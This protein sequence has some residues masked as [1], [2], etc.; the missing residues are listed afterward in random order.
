MLLLACGSSHA[1]LGEKRST[2][3]TGTT[4]STT[5]APQLRAQASTLQTAGVTQQA[6]PLPN[7]T[8][9]VEYMDRNGTVFAVTWEGPVL[10]DLP[11]TLGR[12][13]A[14]FKSEVQQL[15]TASRR[16]G[17][18]NLRGSDLV[19]HSEG[20]MRRFSGYAYVVSLVPPGLN[21]QDVLP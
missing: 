14:Q 1:T 4:A 9:V 16:A 3:A 11:A 20:R 10:P 2:S 18:L 8:S 5:A 17:V 15:G 21:L 6:T 12:Y 7:G 19:V 13:F